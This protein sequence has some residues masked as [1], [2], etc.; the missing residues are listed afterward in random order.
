MFGVWRK[1]FVLQVLFIWV[2]VVFIPFL[3]RLMIALQLALLKSCNLWRVP[4]YKIF[5]KFARSSLKFS[6]VYL[7]NRGIHRREWIL[8]SLPLRAKLVKVKICI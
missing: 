8:R 1:V 5:L 6:A 4:A 3:Q 2:L 7:Y